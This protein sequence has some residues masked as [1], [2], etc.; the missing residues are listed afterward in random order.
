MGQPIVVTEKPSSNRGVVRFETNRALTGMGHERYLAGSEVWGNRPPDEL[1]R[2][3]LAHGGV[4]GVQ[5]NSNVVTVDLDRGFTSE[6]LKSIIEN[7]YRFYPDA[8]EGEGDP[9]TDPAEA[10][11]P[12]AAEAPEQAADP[13]DATAAVADDAPAFEPVDAAEA[14]R[15]ARA[16]EAPE[17]AA[18]VEAP[19]EAAA[20]DP[21]PADVEPAAA[22]EAP[23]EAAV[24][25][26]ADADEAPE[27]ETP[28]VTGRVDGGSEP[29]LGEEPDLSSLP[30]PGPAADGEPIA[31][32]GPADA[33]PA[34]PVAPD[35]PDDAVEPVLAA[36]PEATPD[37][38]QAEAAEGAG[39][40]GAAPDAPVDD[41]DADEAAGA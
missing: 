29:P 41:V 2:R 14:V 9:A 19:A 18:T 39:G 15:P 33:V 24:E 3:L 8:P 1:A 22:E 13:A 17:P 38:P 23:A 28:A 32:K 5:I 27:P 35:A 7:L 26:A 4:L 36:E 31:A 16:D 20:A 10:P 34:E 6:G 21:A 37:S 30:G 25:P 11:E 40:A 12:E